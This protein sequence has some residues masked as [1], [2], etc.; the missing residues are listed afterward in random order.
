MPNTATGLTT[1]FTTGEETVYG[2]PVT[3]DR[4]IEILSESLQRENKIVESKGLR[5]QPITL[6]RGSRRALS[7]R[8][9][10]G[11]VGVEVPTVGFGRWLKHALGGTPTIV[12]QG[13]TA[14]WLQTHTLGT[15]QGRSLTVQKQ[16]RDS[17]NALVQQF[18][19]HGS[20]I[21]STEITI[22]VDGLLEAKFDVDC[23]DEDTTTPAATMAYPA[24]AGS[25][26]FSQGL[27]KIGAVQVA[28]VNDATI[29]LDRKSKTDGWYLGT[30]GLKAEPVENDYPEVEGSLGFEFDSAAMAAY[31]NRFAAD[32]PAELILEFT[33]PIIAST[34]PYLF[35]VTV[36][37]VRFTGETPKVGGPNLVMPKV[38]FQGAF[39]GT[40][41]AFKV[42]YQSTDIAV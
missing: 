21:L 6:R 12:Q 3:C 19:Y 16:L 37:E 35:R 5:S 20:K 8:H 4:S 28:K 42:E 41:G 2:T 23:E 29:K 25:F 40:L 24:A 39:D 10:K 14:A 1:G 15:T 11:D 18:T 32:T 22:S 31:Y 7:A 30:G 9:A 26:N 34:F 36:P 27:L 13:A 38:P 33:G 17:A